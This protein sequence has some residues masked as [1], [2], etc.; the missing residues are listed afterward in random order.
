MINRSGSGSSAHARE[1]GR[2]IGAG[3]TAVGWGRLGWDDEGGL[4]EEV[5]HAHT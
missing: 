1:S 3:L 5:A 4:S 2:A